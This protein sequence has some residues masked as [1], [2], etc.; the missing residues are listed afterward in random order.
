MLCWANE[1]WT[2]RWDGKENECLLKQKYS[3]S[4]DLEHI[5]TLIPYFQDIRYIKI[6]N[7]PVFAIYRLSL[8]PDIRN[9]IKI[10][11]KESAKMSMEL[12][13]CRFE[14]SRDSEK[15]FQNSGFDAV[16]PFPPFAYRM[17]FMNKFFSSHYLYKIIQYLSNARI[18]HIW[19]YD[20]IVKLDL[21]NLYKNDFKSSKIFP[22]CCPGWDNTSRRPRVSI[23][24]VDNTPEK[25]GNWFKNIVKYVEIKHTEDK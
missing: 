14:N 7:K 23:I 16:I 24:V 4:D 8:L 5:K 22:C 18:R 2:R 3:P 9:T 12:Y 19:I 10:W 11:R 17:T 21:Q 15:D 1:N 6:N 25:F 20:N 13:I